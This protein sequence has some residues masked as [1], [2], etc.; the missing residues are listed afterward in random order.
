MNFNSIQLGSLLSLRAK[1]HQR[2]LT[3]FVDFDFRLL[4]KTNLRK[5]NHCDPSHYRHIKPNKNRSL[6]FDLL[7]LFLFM[8]FC[9]I[10]DIIHK[11]SC[12]GCPVQS[13]FLTNILVA[14][15]SYIHVITPLLWT[16]DIGLR[17][18]VQDFVSFL[19]NRQHCF[20]N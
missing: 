2:R 15:G 1:C 18:F 7:R 3:N 9:N 20:F 10:F 13:M 19:S 4:L 6:L 17:F 14:R 5:L 11:L 16:L 12:C 8:V